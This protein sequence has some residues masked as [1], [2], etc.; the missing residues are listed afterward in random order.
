MRIV[1]EGTYGRLK[2]ESGVHRVQRVPL[3]ESQG[4]IHT[5]TATVAILPE[6]PSLSETIPERELRI[7]VYRS[8]GAGGQNA[9]KTNSAVRAVHLPTGITVCIQEERCQQTNRTRALAIL[10][11]RVYQQKREAM[12]A[13]RRDQRQGLIG[14]AE[15]SE[16]IRTYNFPQ[17]RITDHRLGHSLFSLEAFFAGRSLDDLIDRLALHEE[18]RR[19]EDLQ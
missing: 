6:P 7:D 16:K 4:R 11:A 15:R 5:S 19:L 10:R 14:Q 12:M 8:S 13:A 1:G 9:N 3:T 2:F 17:G 18:A